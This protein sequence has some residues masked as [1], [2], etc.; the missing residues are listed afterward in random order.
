[1][2]S[3]RHP[4]PRHVRKRRTTNALERTDSG[5]TVMAQGSDHAPCPRCCQVSTSHSRYVRTLKDLPALGAAVSLRVRVGRWRCRRPGCAVR[6]FTGGL[7]GVA[8]IR[9]RRTCRADVVT[10]L[11][12]YALGGR[13]GERLMGRLGLPVSDDTILQGYSTTA[14]RHAQAVDVCETD[15]QPTVPSEARRV[16]HDPSAEFLRK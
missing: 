7:S 13:P 16:R 6:F 1:V 15:C 12:G 5:W 2:T 11:I 9:G 3:T 10:Q 14:L 8:E 4:Q